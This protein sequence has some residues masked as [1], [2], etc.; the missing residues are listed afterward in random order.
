MKRYIFTL[1]FIL[2]SGCKSTDNSHVDIRPHLL[3]FA[4]ESGNEVV[5]ETPEEIFQ[6]GENANQYV[7]QLLFTHP[8]P[9]KRMK[10][11]VRD[12]FDRTDFNLL[13][14]G[15]ANTVANDTF[16]N[17]MANCLSLSILT[18]ALASKAH[19]DVEFQEIEIPEYWTRRKGRSLLNGHINLRISPPE[20]AGTLHLTKRS[21]VVD[22]DPFSPKKVL[23]AKEVG[24]ARV[25]AMFYNNKGAD[26]M[27]DGDYNAAYAY[28]KESILTDASFQAS[29]INL[30]IL[31][32]MTNHYDWAE[33][34]YKQVLALDP[35]NL[36]T[37]ENLAVLYNMRG[38]TK[39]YQKIMTQVDARRRS[40]P[41]FHYI[42]GEENRE[43]GAYRIAINH[44]QRAIR[45][46]NDKHEFYFGLAKS[47]AA[48]GDV[49]TS[50][51]YLRRAKR[52]APF[53][54]EKSRYQ[55]KIDLLSKL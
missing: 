44:Y 30:G 27:L 51:K 13:Y 46:E 14:D 48:L 35:G 25:L 1:I 26:A 15:K 43:S 54:D 29:I 11:I 7:T 23:P 6:L 4:F 45:L 32:R 36:T 34:T 37:L 24:K 39:K 50:E 22:F 2:L 53:D 10:Q 38:E 42:R 49:T 9:V 31:Y 18:Y 5:I 40:N 3:D 19:L 12:M 52:F 41:Y 33:N 8:D 47:Y 55:S 20:K 17:K 16:N 21:V 28:L